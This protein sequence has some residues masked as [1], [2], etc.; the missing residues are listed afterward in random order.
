[1]VKIFVGSI[2]FKDEP[3][4]SFFYRQALGFNFFF[5]ECLQIIIFLFH[6]NDLIFFYRRASGSNFFL[7]ELPRAPG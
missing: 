5:S 2:F 4:V 1:M 6:R 7:G 3:P